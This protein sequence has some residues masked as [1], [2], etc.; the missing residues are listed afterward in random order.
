M[1]AN[2]PSS[3]SPHRTGVSAAVAVASVVTLALALALARWRTGAAADPAPP[4]G[5]RDRLPG[6][7]PDAVLFLDFDRD[8]EVR[9]SHG[10]RRVEGRYGTAIEFGDAL[11]YAEVPDFSRRQIS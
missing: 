1:R 8:A 3:P 7:P 10:A 6:A 11:Q 4:D 5:G 9:L 2:R